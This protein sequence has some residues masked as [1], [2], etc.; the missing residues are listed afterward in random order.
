M[1]IEEVFTW[2]ESFSGGP[3]SVWYF[4]IRCGQRGL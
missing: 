4:E 2:G 1:F 3:V